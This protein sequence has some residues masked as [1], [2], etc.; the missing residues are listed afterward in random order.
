LSQSVCPEEIEKLKT[1]KPTTIYAASRIPG[2]RPTTLIYLHQF[3][4]K[5]KHVEVEEKDVL[6]M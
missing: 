3:I 4:R 5:K 6:D 1:H 2:I